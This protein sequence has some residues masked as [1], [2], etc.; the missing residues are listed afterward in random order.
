MGNQISCNCEFGEM[1]GNVLSIIF[2]QLHQLWFWW[3]EQFRYLLPSRTRNNDRNRLQVII[4]DEETCSFI[5]TNNS[6]TDNEPVSIDS[7][8]SS[9]ARKI[10]AKRYGIDVHLPD[11]LFLTKTQILPTFAK[12]KIRQILSAGLSN[13][14]ALEVNDLNQYLTAW[15]SLQQAELPA[16]KFRAVLY[17][18]KRGLA[19]KVFQAAKQARVDLNGIIISD[20]VDGETRSFN[21][22]PSLDHP[23]LFRQRSIRNRLMLILVIL[24]LG[25]SWFIAGQI[26]RRQQQALDDLDQLL[27]VASSK[28]KQVRRQIDDRNLVYRELSALRK[29]KGGKNSIHEV[30]EQVTNALPDAVWLSELRL[31]PKNLILSGFAISAADIIKPLENI[32][33]FTEVKF[34]APIIRSAQFDRERFSIH[35]STLDVQLAKESKGSGDE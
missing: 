15:R 5:T 10:Q 11:R 16:D 9:S 30:L 20:N 18:L 14:T 21:I 13:N 12:H 19:D 34:T 32:S 4:C 28:A 1:M 31:K 27:I 23:H 26:D 22:L 25:G 6:E 24:V 2:N 7:F 35:I 29:A 33:G 3:K 8:L 17:V